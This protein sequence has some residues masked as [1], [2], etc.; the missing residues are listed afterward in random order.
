MAAA[1]YAAVD[2]DSVAAPERPVEAEA[3][4]AEREGG[5]AGVPGDAVGERGGRSLVADRR[6]GGPAAV[7]VGKAR[8]DH[9]AGPVSKE[10]IMNKS[11]FSGEIFWKP[12]DLIKAGSRLDSV[13]KHCE[14]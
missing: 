2:A 10:S 1:A 14:T 7:E 12:H 3:G 11:K 5:H 13:S 8:E 9:V 6:G 4:D